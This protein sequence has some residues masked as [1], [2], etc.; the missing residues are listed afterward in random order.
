MKKFKFRLER[1]LAYRG[2]QKDEKKRELLLKNKRVGDIQAELNQLESLVLENK[3]DASDVFLSQFIHLSGDYALRLRTE[4]AEQ[5][6]KLEKA[7]EEA[8]EALQ[9]YLEASR[10]EKKLVTLKERRLKEYKTMCQNEEAKQL[11]ELNIQSRN[12][13]LVAQ[14]GERE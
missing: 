10:E 12:N 11:D 14:I 7:L 9:S 2:A 8:K 5:K 6:I 3:I 13:A 4:I 1:V